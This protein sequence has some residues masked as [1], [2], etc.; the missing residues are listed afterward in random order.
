MAGNKAVEITL[1][2]VTSVGG[3]LEI[4]SIA[5]AAQAGALF[6]YRLI[7]AAVLGGVCV[8]FLVEQSGRLAAVSGLTI[9]AAIRERFGFSY[10]FVL[11]VLLAPVSLLTLAAEIGGI[12][13]ALEFTTGVAYRWWTAPAMLFVWLLLWKGKFSA[14]EQGVSFLGLVTVCF[15]VGA[16]R[17]GPDWSEVLL[18]IAPAL[19]PHD[20]GRY[21]FIAVSILGASITPYLMFF[22]SSGAIEDKWNRSYLSANRA[23]AG[24]GMAFGT[25]I[26][27]GVLIVSSL[28]LA[29][30]GMELDDYSKLA[31]LLDDAFGASGL[32]LIIGSLIIACVGA[33]LEITLGLAY[34]I[35]QGSGWNWSEDPKPRREARF[36]CAYTLMLIVAGLVVLCGPEPL[37]LTNFAMAL[38]A[39][40]LPVAIVPFLFVMNDPRYV[41]EHRNGTLSNGVVL[42]I[43]GLAFVLAVVAIPLEFIGGS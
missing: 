6:G 31:V 25:L 16:F 42:F 1:G 30:R 39:A 40:T 9:A 3:F 29:P 41:K 4:G 23:I 21:W 14:I 36:C 32:K 19:P 34:I 35:A 22:Y 33:A 24:I 38:T 37:K 17:L 18:R 10:W 11:L 8:A 28:T 20:A 26:A 13:I 7:W 2:I 12:S 27:I 43:I 5:T 15:I